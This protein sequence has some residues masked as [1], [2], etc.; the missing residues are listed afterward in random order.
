MIKK[1]DF[2]LQQLNIFLQIWEIKYYLWLISSFLSSKKSIFF[3]V[4]RVYLRSTVDAVEF[5]LPPSER[6]LVPPGG[7]LPHRLVFV[8]RRRYPRLLHV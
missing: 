1:S 6:D 4:M 2:I 7:V 8:E 3:Q 5:D